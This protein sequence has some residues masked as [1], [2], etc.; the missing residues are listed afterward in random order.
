MIHL[1]QSTRFSWTLLPAIAP[2]TFCGAGPGNHFLKQ[3]ASSSWCRGNIDAQRNRGHRRLVGRGV[4]PDPEAAY[5][6]FIAAAEHGDP[7][8]I[9]NVGY[10][11]LRVR[12]GGGSVRVHKRGFG[13]E[14]LPEGCAGQIA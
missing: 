8:G 12:S 5:R 11:Y 1:V 2:F 13:V 9:F 10:M 4:A 3:L 6:D 14:R 7:F